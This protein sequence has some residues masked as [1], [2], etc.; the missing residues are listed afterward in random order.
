MTPGPID[1]FFEWLST[2]PADARTAVVVD[3][4]RLLAEAGFLGKATR[5]DQTGRTWQLVVFR[6]DDLTF[7]LAYRRAHLVGQIETLHQSQEELLGL[8]GAVAQLGSGFLLAQRA[9]HE[10]DAPGLKSRGIREL[11][12]GY[13]GSVLGSHGD[14]KNVIIGHPIRV[15]K[16]GL[17]P[18]FRARTRTRTRARSTRCPR[19]AIVHQP[20]P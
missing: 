20:S 3:G 6:G 4:D 16:M 9:P 1:T 14:T 10:S 13:T 2:R 7:R 5:T 12:M 11:A 8:D 18:S 19:S 17:S 15:R